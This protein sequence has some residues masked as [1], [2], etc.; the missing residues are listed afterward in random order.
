MKGALN[1]QRSFSKCSFPTPQAGHVQLSGMSSNAVPGAIPFSGSPSA[2]SYMYPQMIQTYFSIKC[3]SFIVTADAYQILSRT[4]GVS[5]KSIKYVKIAIGNKFCCIF[6][7]LLDYL[8]WKT[9]HFTIFLLLNSEVFS[10]MP[11]AWEWVMISISWMLLCRKLIVRS[12][13]HAVS[14]DSCFCI[15]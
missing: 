8:L 9:L 13:I 10:L 6:G 3:S 12:V 14:M 1:F 7:A 15:V 11:L 4:F 5:K 2:G